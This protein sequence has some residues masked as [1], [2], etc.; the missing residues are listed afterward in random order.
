MKIFSTWVRKGVK[1][2]NVI[3][4][5]LTSLFPLNFSSCGFSQTTH[6]STPGSSPRSP[7]VHLVTDVGERI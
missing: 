7:G 2:L 1:G 4:Q 5:L 6:A 3:W